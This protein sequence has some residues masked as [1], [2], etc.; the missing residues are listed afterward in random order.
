MRFQ[1]NTGAYWNIFLRYHAYLDLFSFPNDYNSISL[2]FFRIFHIFF[3]HAILYHWHALPNHLTGTCPALLLV[4]NSDSCP[5]TQEVYLDPSLN[6][7]RG[8]MNPSQYMWGFLCMK[9]TLFYSKLKTM[10]SVDGHQPVLFKVI[11]QNN[12]VAVPRSVPKKN[13]YFPQ[14]HP[15]HDE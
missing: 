3:G 11:T 15:S 7:F 6:L 5:I 10:S 13:I 4:R 2:S 12:A 8:C 1:Q 9:S 14:L